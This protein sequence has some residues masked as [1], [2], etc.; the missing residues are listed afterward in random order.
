[1]FWGLKSLSLQSYIPYSVI[2]VFMKK[3]WHTILTRHYAPF[4]YKPSLTICINLLRRYIYLQFTHPSAIHGKFNKNGR[5]L[6]LWWMRGR[7]EITIPPWLESSYLL[8]SNTP[9]PNDWLCSGR[10]V[11]SWWWCENCIVFSDHTHSAPLPCR[12][13]PLRASSQATRDGDGQFCHCYFPRALHSTAR[14]G[15]V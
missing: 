9:R 15:A 4:D 2:L 3:Q 10:L 1:M 7:L 5:T 11:A 8:A 13:E 14:K 12:T 6:Q